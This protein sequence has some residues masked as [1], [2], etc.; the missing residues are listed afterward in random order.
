V[1]PIS[2]LLVDNSVPTQIDNNENPKIEATAP[3]NIRQFR[4]ATLITL[5]KI[6]EL[7]DSQLP[8]DYDVRLIETVAIRRIVHQY[9]K[10]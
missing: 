4:V 8:Q 9:N 6:Q 7:V 10:S 1:L 2:A 5:Y 3:A